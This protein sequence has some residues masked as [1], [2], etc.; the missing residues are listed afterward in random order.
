MSRRSRTSWRSAQAVTLVEVL[1]GLTLLGTILAAILIA[2]GRVVVQDRL[3]ERRLEACHVLDGLLEQ[4]W[5]QPDRIPQAGQG[6]VPGDPAW[7]WQTRTVTSADAEA[8]GAAVVQVELHRTGE[9]AA[10]PAAQVEILLPAESKRDG[11]AHAQGR[12]DAG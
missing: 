11:A 5:A 10:Q 8:L 9:E 12:P 6:E 3:A 4:W 7:R 2:R 1:A